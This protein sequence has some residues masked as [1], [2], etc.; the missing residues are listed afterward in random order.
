MVIF[1]QLRLSDDGKRLYIN[2]HINKADYFKKD[3]IK[4]VTVMSSD[5][6]L[7]TNPNNPSSHYLYKQ[8]YKDEDK[9]REV[10]FVL[11]AAN[12]SKTW[13][14]SKGEEE[15][16][17]NNFKESDMSRTLF[18]VYVE[19]AGLI[20]ECTPCGLSGNYTL[21][22]TFDEKLL[23][24]R[25]M[26]YTKALADD[27]NIPTGFIDFILLWNAFKASIET[28]HYVPAIKYWKMLFGEG[29]I[30]NIIYKGCGCH[31]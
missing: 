6:V 29:N 10:N 20:E 31:G 30:G 27:C 8:T 9:V 4:S 5:E 3:Y 23:Y 21:G 28:E 19:C 1:S 24:Q 17:K 26:G 13:L 11:T 25:V 16:V 22:V 15:A 2:C 12:F 7:E 14:K 18:F